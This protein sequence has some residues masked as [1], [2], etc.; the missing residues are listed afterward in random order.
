M[1]YQQT[2]QRW[3]DIDRQRLAVVR[4]KLA[5]ADVL[6]RERRVRALTQAEVARRM[7][8]SQ[9]RVATIEAGAPVVRI[10][11]LMRALLAVGASMSDIGRAIASADLR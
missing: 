9:P 1:A 7:G 11:L 3:L 6:R 5:L 8:S 10:E 2:D 4:A